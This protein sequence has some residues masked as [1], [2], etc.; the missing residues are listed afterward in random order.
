MNADG[1]A[2][3][4]DPAVN[5]YLLALMQISEMVAQL[6]RQVALYRTKLEG[7]GFSPTMAEYM[8]YQYH[9]GLINT[10]FAPKPAVT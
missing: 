9:G 2:E 5:A 6:P 1:K 10:F 7:E 3:S 4:G 8:A